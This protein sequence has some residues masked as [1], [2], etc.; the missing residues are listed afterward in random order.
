MLWNGRRPSVHWCSTLAPPTVA[1]TATLAACIASI[2]RALPQHRKLAKPYLRA[3]AELATAVRAAQTISTDLQAMVAEAYAAGLIAEPRYADSATALV[4][5]R[6][7]VQTPAPTG[8]LDDAQIE[9]VRALEAERSALRRE[10]RELGEL[11]Q[12]AALERS[13]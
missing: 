6:S 7:V 13:R 5:L 4:A 2:A 10:L 3:E 12:E 9:R 8:Q 11:H 1:S